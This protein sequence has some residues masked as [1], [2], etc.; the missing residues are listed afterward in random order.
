MLRNT[1]RAEK[2]VWFPGWFLPPKGIFQE[3]KVL[4]SGGEDVVPG[5]AMRKA[6]FV[7]GCSDDWPVLT[8]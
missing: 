7:R 6:Y 8:V 5:I 2:R 1:D 3:L 4:W